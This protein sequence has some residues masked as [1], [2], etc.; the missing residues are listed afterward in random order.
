MAINPIK[1]LRPIALLLCLSLLLGVAG[2]A[3][4]IGVRSID[5]RDTQRLLTANVLSTGDPSSWSTQTLQRA[6]LFERFKNDPGAT[7]AELHETLAPKVSP[8]KLFALSELSFYFAEQS[9]RIEHFRAAAVY[10]YAF[11]FPEGGIRPPDPLDPRRRLAA[12]LYNRSL[13]RALALSSHKTEDGKKGGEVALQARTI[14]LPFGELEISTQPDEFLWGG[15]RFKRFIP[16][17]EFEV[18]GFRNRYRQAGIGA[19]L[20]AE[21]EPNGS[22]A[23][24]ETAR[25]RIP[26]GIKVPVTVFVRIENPRRGILTK[27]LKGRVEV[28]AADEDVSVTI[29]GRDVPL[30]LEST[31]ALAYG[32]DG[33]AIWDFEIAGFRFADKQQVFGDGLI[34]M[35]PY[36]PG[37]IPV[38]LVHGTASSP[39]RWAEM[40]NEFTHDPLIRGRFQFWLF[41]YNTGQPVLYSAHLMRQA[42]HAIITDL[43][44]SGKDDALRQMVL[45]GHSQGGLLI[46]LMAL[47]SGTRFWDNASKVPFEEVQMAPET[48]Q[49]L[50]QAIF[51]EPVPTVKRVIFIATP[52]RGSYRASGFVLTLVRKLVRLPRT[53][54]SL[55]EELIED[56]AFAELNSSQPSNSVENMNPKHPFTRTLSSIPIDA[57]IAAH[58]IIAVRGEGPLSGRTDGVVSYDSAHIEGVESE[59]IV[60]SSHSTQSHPETI[61]EVRR[62]LRK[63]VGIQ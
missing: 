40:I 52:H 45:V 6:N 38:V 59:K 29:N 9:G 10:A 17:A 61:E 1:L 34:M 14:P 57:G 56:P 37:R 63:H 33:A 31:A 39:A 27:K 46:K 26:P 43:D 60:Q 13:T 21:L 3:T 12:D 35:H 23:A 11:L 62:I 22:G 42:L 8:D 55:F 15:Y 41:Q 7:L 54:V 50:R 25:K 19:P 24:A 28:Y 58:S 32:L 44:P 30:E 48:R 4:P 51:F 2:C 47:H 5:P 36:R 16:V 18:R 20:A 49:L 53:V